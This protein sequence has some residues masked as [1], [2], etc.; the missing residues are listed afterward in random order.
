MSANGTIKSDEEK[1]TLSRRI[2]ETRNSLQTERLD[3]SFGEIMSVYEDGEL[4]INPEFQRLFRWS[5]EQQTRFLESLV[6]GIPIPP[7]FVAEDANGKWE[8]VDGLQRVS[9]VLS[10]F[11]LL[12]SDQ[13]KNKWIMSEGEL[14][15]ELEG[16][17]VETFP[18][19]FIINIK[20]AV[21]R[22]E[23]I[24][25]NSAMDLRYELFNRL[26][27]GGTPLTEQEIRNCIFRGTSPKFNEYLAE[28]SSIP[29]FIELVKITKSK[30]DQMYLDELVLRFTSLVF[31]WDEINEGLSNYMTKFMK[32]A[33]ENPEFDY[34]KFKNLF[35]RTI[36]LLSNY[37]SEIFLASNS[38]FSTSLYEGITIG[39]ANNIDYYE[40]NN[41]ALKHK[42]EE[43]KNDREFNTYMGSAASSKNRVKKRIWR[44]IRIFENFQ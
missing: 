43:I 41:S 25:W 18:F 22:V 37:G 26:N 30:V 10:F 4:I 19:K 1:S 44:A 38:G 16:F 15:D 33:V 8:L 39:V 40:K 14:I 11:G 28:M 42:I 34:D 17:N 31:D 9:T 21:C 36:H 32:K 7:I 35:V 13:R 23:I 20:R 24:R 3:M 12:K 2:E 27:T 5:K 29:E 6:L